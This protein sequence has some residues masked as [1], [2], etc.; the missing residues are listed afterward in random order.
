MRTRRVGSLTED[1]LE[2]LAIELCR[3]CELLISSVPQPA[4]PILMMIPDNRSS[5]RETR[6]QSR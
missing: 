4:S 5:L 6:R 3:G 2:D 1:D